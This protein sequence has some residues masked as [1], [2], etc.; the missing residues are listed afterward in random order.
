MVTLEQFKTATGIKDKDEQISTLIPLVV[1]QVKGYCNMDKLP[2]DYDLN[3]IKMVEY[4][5][6]NNPSVSSESLSRHSV[7][8]MT[9]YPSSITKG[10]RRRL[11]W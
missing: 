10:L 3:I 4:N 9:D 2:S 6:K 11:R 1:E 8:Y 7:T 5:L